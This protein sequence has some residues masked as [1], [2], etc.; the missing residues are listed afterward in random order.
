MTTLKLTKIQFTKLIMNH[1]T[2]GQSLLPCCGTTTVDTSGGGG[3]G[4][5]WGFIID[6]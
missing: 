4:L 3:G 2:Q 5:D 6:I 1:L